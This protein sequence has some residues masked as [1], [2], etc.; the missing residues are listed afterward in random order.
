MSQSP[1]EG[2]PTRIAVIGGGAAGTVA[3]VHLLREARLG[4]AE[5]L[6]I[7]RDGE[8]GPGVP[9][10]TEDPQHV[11]NVPACRMGAVAGDPEHFHR[12]LLAGGEEVGPEAFLPRGVFGAYLRDLLDRSE[13]E[14]A[15]RVSLRRVTGEVVSIAAGSSLDVRLANGDSLE[16]DRAILAVGPLPSADPVTVPAQLRDGRYLADPWAP[17]ALE[18]ARR[19]RSVLIIGTGLSMVDVALSL[20]E[21]DG[22]PAIRAVSRHGLLPRR[23]RPDLTRVQPFE[24]PLE[25]GDLAPVVAAVF[26]RIGLVTQEG[27]DWR[28]VLDSL[29]PQ[30]ANVWRSLRVEEKRR[31]FTEMQ[32]FWDVHRFRMAPAVA[33][34][35]DALLERG[36]VRADARS[37][38]SLEETPGGV[39]VLLRAGGQDEL[40]ML[41]V[42]RVIKCA[43][44][45]YEIDKQAPPLIADL[46]QRGLARPDDL[47]LGLDVDPVGAALIDAEGRSSDRIHVVGA[48]RK[49][50][51]W[52]AIGIT[53]IRDHSAAATEAAVAAALSRAARP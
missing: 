38:V 17:G 44:A 45:G 28:D 1:A 49:G 33:D 32:R 36:A 14:S 3:A 19:D 4:S 18:A 7:D 43:G 21:G 27:G 35:F 11:L 15:G 30:T 23:H 8:Y 24:V 13:R 41:E 53:E 20:S 29:R 22:G 47:S 26:E 9:Y 12:W 6:L 42:D 46:L 40:E 2:P 50:V 51:E 5:V 31:F 25:S 16:V 10:R 52:E 39:R 48:L 37:I 34:R